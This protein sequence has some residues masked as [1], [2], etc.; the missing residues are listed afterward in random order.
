MMGH[1]KDWLL[2]S[3]S[4]QEHIKWRGVGDS[5]S[6][7]HSTLPQEIPSRFD[8]VCFL[9]TLSDD[10]CVRC[11]LKYTCPEILE[12][13]LVLISGPFLDHFPGLVRKSKILDL[14]K[15]CILKSLLPWMGPIWVAIW[16]LS[17]RYARQVGDY[18]GANFTLTKNMDVLGTFLRRRLPYTWR[19]SQILVWSHS[20]L[21]IPSV[22][23]SQISPVNTFCTI[24]SFGWLDCSGQP[25][26][27][28]TQ[29]GRPDSGTQH[30]KVKQ[31]NNKT[32]H[33]S[34][35]SESE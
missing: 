3:F 24:C 9:C 18:P 28:S 2:C 5:G 17:L 31:D 10:H 14:R 34:Q 13:E 15:H 16:C 21:W 30:L 32:E 27:W 8:Q 26:T 12:L 35:L 33:L 20:A 25:G 7:V 19:E 1:K 29:R 4:S 22:Q 23:D 11:S 6:L